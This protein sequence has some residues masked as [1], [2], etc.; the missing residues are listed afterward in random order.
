LK[1]YPLVSLS[2]KIL[3]VFLLFYSSLVRR[4][5]AWEKPA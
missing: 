4:R 3:T 2:G 5:P 1:M